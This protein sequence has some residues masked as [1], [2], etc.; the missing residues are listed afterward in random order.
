MKKFPKL[1]FILPLFV[2]FLF[3][4]FYFL[5]SGINVFAAKFYF[6]PIINEISAG[7]QFSVNL[8]LDTEN[9]GINAL[10]GKVVFFDNLELISI[11]EGNSLISLWAV[12][13]ALT[14]SS[15]ESYILYSGLVPGG[16]QGDLSA[17]WQGYQP[18]KVFELIFK[19]KETGLAQI[20]TEDAKVLLNDG[21]ATETELS[22]M[23]Y[24]LRII[25][26][27]RDADSDSDVPDS[28]F[29]SEAQSSSLEDRQD[30]GSETQYSSGGS[31]AQNN[32]VDV[33]PPEDFQPVI[34]RIPEISGDKWFLV[35][36]SQDK[37]SGIDHYEIQENR[38]QK[39]ENKAIEDKEWAAAESPHLLNDQKLR[40][41]VYVKAVDKASNEKITMLPPQNPLAWYEK[42]WVWGIIILVV[43][44]AYA[45]RVII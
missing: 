1:K 10:E 14:A 38:N 41:Y 28:R 37:D 6:E 19:A 2:F 4:A 44:M 20:N 40:S 16:Y 22:V 3:S 18:G 5:F 13:P 39:I 34:T 35:F 11:N 24:A 30:S 9:Q 15:G 17:Y 29:D 8:M 25:E 31:V 26:E 43:F 21:K 32:V 36:N 7:E 42:Y 12:K 23:N 33:E 27:I 45:I